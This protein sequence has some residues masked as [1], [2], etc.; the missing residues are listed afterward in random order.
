MLL[1]ALGRLVPPALAGPLMSLVGEPLFPDWL[2]KS[3]FRDRG[4]R[5]APRAQGRGRD[6]LRKELLCC[7]EDVTLPQ[8][9]RSEDRNSMAFSIESR[10]PFCVPALAEFA[11]GLPASYLVRPDGDQKAVVRAAMA[12]IVPEQILRRPKIGFT[13]PEQSWLRVLAPWLE[14]TVNSELL[15]TLPF[16]DQAAVRRLMVEQLGSRYYDSAYLWRVV[17][18]VN[19]MRIFDVAAV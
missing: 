12:G 14:A 6:T 8:I 3:W 7:I 9:L 11:L 17:N 18:V 10:V 4:I 16:L 13:T 19:W 2:R 1:S 5:A 15:A